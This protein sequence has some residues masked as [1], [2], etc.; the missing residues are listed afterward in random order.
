MRPQA[1][2]QLL[3]ASFVANLYYAPR[4]SS[5]YTVWSRILAIYLSESLSFHIS[6]MQFPQNFVDFV[7]YRVGVITTIL[8][9]LIKGKRLHSS[10][11][12]LYI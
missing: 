6:T 3:N 2:F 10:Y 11:I 8:N 12:G 1:S 9:S 5:D 7:Y 4:A